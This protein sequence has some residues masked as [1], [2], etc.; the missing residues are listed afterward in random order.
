M[1][2]YYLW[3]W[4]SWT[5][6][7]ESMYQLMSSFIIL[8]C[9]MRKAGTHPASGSIRLQR[10]AAEEKKKKVKVAFK[11]FILIHYQWRTICRCSGRRKRLWDVK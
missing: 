11:P 6:R 5:H 4:L 1:G 10:Q 3:L 7:F 9:R 8:F 2:F